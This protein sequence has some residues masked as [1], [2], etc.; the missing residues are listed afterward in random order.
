MS[1]PSHITILQN[2]NPIK[3]GVL[4]LLE[5]SILYSLNF[6]ILENLFHIYC[7]PASLSCTSQYA[8]LV[9]YVA[10]LFALVGYVVCPQRL[11]WFSQ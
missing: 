10:M 8:S 11:A 2:L 6:F 4:S 7:V 5:Q 3:C 1:L 9:G